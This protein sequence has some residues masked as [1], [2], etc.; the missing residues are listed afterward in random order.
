MRSR[1]RRPRDARPRAR[2]APSPPRRRRSS[3][4]SCVAGCA[5]ADAAKPGSLLRVRGTGMR[6]VAKIVFLGGGGHDDNATVRVSKA[7]RDSVDV[8]VPEK[9]RSGRLRAV[10]GDGARSA[11]AAPSSR[12]SAAR[13]A[14]PRST[15]RSSGAAST[16]TRRARRA[17]TCWPGSAMAVTVALVRVIDGAVVMAWPV[18]LVPEAVSSITWDGRVEG[19]AQPAGRYE[20]RVFEAVAGAGV[21]AASAPAA[22]AAGGFDLVDHI[23]PVRGRHTYGSGQAAFGAAAQRPHAPG[24]RRVR[25][26][27]HAARGGARR[28]REAQPLRALGRQLRRHRRRGHR[29]RLRLHA[30][31]RALA[32]ARRARACS[33]GRRSATSATPATR[34]AATCTSS[35]GAGP[36]W[37]TGGAAGRSAAV[38]EGLGRLQLTRWRRAPPKPAASARVLKRSEPMYVAPG[39]PA[40]PS[41]SAYS[42]GPIVAPASRATAR[43]SFALAEPS[44]K[45]VRTPVE[46]IVRTRRATS[47]AGGLRLRRDAGDH[48]ADDLDRVAVGV[49]AER[50]V[51]GDE[52]APR[53]RD[54]AHARRDRAR[55]ARAA[56]RCRRRRSPC[57]PRGRPG[58]R[59]SSRRGCGRT[60]A[61][62]LRGSCHQCGSIPPSPRRVRTASISVVV[63]GV[64]AGVV[65]DVVEPVVERRRRSAG[66]PR[67]RRRPSRRSGAAR[68]RA[69]RSWAAGSGGPRRARRRPRGRGRRPASSWRP[70]CARRPRRPRLD[71]RRRA[72]RRPGRRRATASVRRASTRPTL[73][74][75]DSR[76]GAPAAT[77]ARARPTSSS[78][79]RWRRR[80]RRWRPS[81]SPSPGDRGSGPA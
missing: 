65:D 48:G 6:E 64:R 14:R 60:A 18:A 77:P 33:R 34:A 39:L 68:R 79:A 4:S 12:S 59:R 46:R 41:V 56:A 67:R 15:S 71:R 53:R 42:A 8:H 13:G 32:G 3:R 63:A 44:G 78:R 70:R 75:N 81:P 74:E 20:F 40:G 61:I 11:A 10:N 30:P 38:P 69:D 7:R 50:V 58:R 52:P 51:V 80:R 62:A 72:A 23:F 37:Y 21:V 1:T 16:T 9:A 27:R 17:S 22:L 26:L 28:R 57:S 5:T 35:C 29:R 36:G 49:G 76:L 54:R 43:A 25:A 45:I 19:V 73:A 47:P 55:R 66:R 2:A 31:A 24:P